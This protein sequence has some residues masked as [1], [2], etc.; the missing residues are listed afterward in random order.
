[1]RALRGQDQSAPEGDASY[2][3]FN[4]LDG[5]RVRDRGTS[6]SLVDRIDTWGFSSLTGY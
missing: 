6:G 5:I 4:G 2:S 3:V 1:M